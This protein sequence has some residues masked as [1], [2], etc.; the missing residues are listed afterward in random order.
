MN[1][2]PSGTAH[3]ASVLPVPAA[4]ALLIVFF[5]LGILYAMCDSAVTTA[6]ES[7]VKRD[8]ENGSRRAKKFLAYLDAN[9]S[10]ASPLQFGMMLM[11]FF[12]I[13]V[14][15][16]GFTPALDNALIAAGLLPGLAAAAAVVLCMLLCAVLFLLAHSPAEDVTAHPPPGPP[17]Y[18][19]GPPLLSC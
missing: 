8:A 6:S 12:S 1:D 17:L 3:A 13:G 5:L 14:S 10:F 19:A 15:V 18:A 9:E 2:D 16:L 4:A 11:G 7:R